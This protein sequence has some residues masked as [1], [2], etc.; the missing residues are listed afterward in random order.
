MLPISGVSTGAVQPLTAAEKAAGPLKIQRP[1]EESRPLKSVTDEY[2]PEEKQEPAGRYWLGKD[3]D[4]QPK[5]YFDNP[6]QP[7]DPP[8]RSA[9]TPAKSPDSS[10]QPDGPSGIKGPKNKEDKEERCAG[11]TDKVDREIERLKKKRQELEQQLRAETDE[12]KAQNLEQELAQVERE[13]REK[14]NDAYRKQHSTF[15]RLS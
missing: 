8:Q 2:V 15:T 14:D 7:A 9:D 5:I 1:K 4:G 13:L 3:K 12:A 6:E 10:Q 11:N